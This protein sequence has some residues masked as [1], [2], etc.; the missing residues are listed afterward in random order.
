MHSRSRE[1]LEY[2]HE[3]GVFVNGEGVIVAIESDCDRSRAEDEI[4]PRLGWDKTQVEVVNSKKGQFFFPGFIGMSRVPP[5]L[6]GRVNKL[7]PTQTPTYHASQYPNVGIF[8]KSTLL[9]WLNTYTFPLE[10]SLKDLAKAR[11]VYAACVRRTLAHGTTTSAYYATVDVAATNLLADTCLA[12]GQR[13]FIGRVCMDH[14]AMCP[15]YYRDES[16]EASLDAARASIAH[17]RKVDP[18]FA[19]VS[20]ILTPRFAPACTP[21]AMRGLAAIHAETDLPIQTH[22]SRERARGGARARHVPGLVVVRR[23]LR[24]PRPADAAHR[25][26]ARRA[27]DRGRGRPRRRPWRQDQPLPGEQQRAH[28]GRGARALDVGQGH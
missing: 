24:R 19:L 3:T 9:D 1:N 14:A 21:E 27:P 2:L 12:L 28:V 8:G 5:D 11:R 4:V 7:T 22:I 17:I 15:D 10:A 26:R 6:P 23:R 16:P 18:S 13:A 25:P 20:P